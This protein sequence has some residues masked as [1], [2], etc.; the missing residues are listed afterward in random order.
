MSESVRIQL[1]KKPRALTCNHDPR[2]GTLERMSERTYRC[3]VCG[4]LFA[5]GVM[6]G[7]K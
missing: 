6:G 5:V 7:A 3:R 1:D 2:N 4:K